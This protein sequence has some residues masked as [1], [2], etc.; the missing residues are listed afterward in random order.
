MINDNIYLIG[1]SGSGKS[2]IGK[3]LAEKLNFDFIDTDNEIEN[4]MDMTINQI[5]IEYGEQYF[6]LLE[7]TFFQERIKNGQVIYSTGGG[8]IL[9]KK[10]QNILGENGKTI[11]LDCMPETIIKRLKNAKTTRPLLSDN[12]N[13]TIQSL[14]KNRYPIYKSC[15]NFV[16]NVDNKKPQ[17]IVS[18]IERFL[19]A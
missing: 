16:I 8:L 7:T 18:I 14:Y 17:S 5:F 6:R 15:S 9:D 3:I 1:L 12:F 13:S 10:N 4:I 19:N 11:F 2:T